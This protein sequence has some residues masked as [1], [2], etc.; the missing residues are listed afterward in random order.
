MNL[1]SGHDEVQRPAFA[2]DNGVDLLVRPPR[3]IPI[4]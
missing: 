4:A 3:L 1:S 2:V